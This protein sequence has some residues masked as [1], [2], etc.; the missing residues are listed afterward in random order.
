MAL[1]VDSGWET[2][3][4]EMTEAEFRVKIAAAKE[5]VEMAMENLRLDAIND[6]LRTFRSM[7]P[8]KAL[9]RRLRHRPPGL[10]C[11]EDRGRLCQFC[12]AKDVW[13]LL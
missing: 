1:N 12:A 7:Y 9:W 8:L 3:G 5:E 13:S 6:H 10:W 4:G 11:E 2:Q